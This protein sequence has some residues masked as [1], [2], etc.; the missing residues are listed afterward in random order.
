ME[1]G[2]VSQKISYIARY[3]LANFVHFPY[4]FLN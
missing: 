4:G 2:T 1:K 3:F